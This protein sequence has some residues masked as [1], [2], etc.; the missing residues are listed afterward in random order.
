MAVDS[1]SCGNMERKWP[2]EFTL[3]AALM[4]A[5]AA[6]LLAPS[7]SDCILQ[8]GL[9]AEMSFDKTGPKRLIMITLDEVIRERYVLV[10]SVEAEYGFTSEAQMLETVLGEL[11]LKPTR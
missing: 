11:Y 1:V 9:L 5:A 10:F 8:V 4:Q 3:I 6:R 7:L 2:T